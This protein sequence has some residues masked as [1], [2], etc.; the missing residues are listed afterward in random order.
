[1]LADER[2]G[3]AMGSESCKPEPVPNG[4]APEVAK[5]LQASSWYAVLEVP[6]HATVEEVRKA[7]KVKSLVTHP[8]KLGTQNRGAHEASVRVNTVRPPACLGSFPPSSAYERFLPIPAACL[9]LVLHC[10]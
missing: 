4:A 5:V 8:D 10:Y 3:M 1:M 6:S 2:A 7:H 9:I